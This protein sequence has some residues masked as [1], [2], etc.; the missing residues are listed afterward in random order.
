M[1]ITING[2]ARIAL[3]AGFA[4]TPAHAEFP[5]DWYVSAGLGW[6]YAHAITLDSIDARVDLDQAIYQPSAALGV[7]V[8]DNW[9]LELDGAIFESTPEIVYSTSQGIEADSDEKDGIKSTS[10]MVNV[11]RE[12][13]IGIAWRPYLGVGI[14]IADVDFRLSELAINSGAIQRPR[15]DIV[16]D[17]TT[18]FAYQLIAGLTVPLTRRLDLSADYRYWATPSLDLEDV[19]G[20]SQDIDYGVHSAWLHLSYHAPDTGVLRSPAPRQKS[21]SGFYL[22]TSLGGGMSE[23]AE[24]KDVVTRITIDAFDFGPTATVAFG[25]A[26]RNRWRFELEGGYR[27]NDVEV[28]DFRLPQGEDGASGEVKSYS[29]MANAIYQFAP[30]S[31][32]RPFLGLGAGI[33]SQSY[34]IDVFGFCEFYVCGPEHSSKFIDDNDSTSVFQ[35]MLGVDVAILPQLTFTTDLRYLRTSDFNM[36]APDGSSFITTHRNT[37]IVVGL[38][39]SFDAKR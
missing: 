2:I 22:S 6:N 28:I 23:D 25:Y 39:Y 16:D 13:P 27:R 29:L 21:V 18:A 30:G 38:R 17:K 35:A 3:L 12:I 24:L 9:R 8:Y 32:I 4:A 11:L 31:S 14:G 15:R 34:D 1:Q 19:N 20:V 7:R 10:L 33:I 36:E 5:R 26:W 37:S